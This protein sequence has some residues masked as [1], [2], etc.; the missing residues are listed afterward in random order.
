MQIQESELQEI[1]KLVTAQ[2]ISILEEKR[3]LG[4]KSA[5]EKTAYQKTEALL[6]NYNGLCKIVK[7]KEQEIAELRMYGVPGTCGGVKEY[8]SK[9][10]LPQGLVLDE[11]RVEAAVHTVLESVHDTVQVIDLIDKSM[12]A[13][14]KDPYYPILEMRYFEGRT[15][16]DV[17]VELKCT[18]QNVSYHKSRLVRELAMRIFPDQVVHEMMS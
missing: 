14:S 16:E 15:L 2:T 12:K 1:I 4:N 3:I 7:E 9:G 11:E 5:N 8:T 13:I 6:F 18:Q 17:G 10:G